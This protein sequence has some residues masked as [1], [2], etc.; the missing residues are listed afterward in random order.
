MKG[1]RSNQLVVLDINK[2][3]MAT[4]E[5]GCVTCAS[6]KECNVLNPGKDKRRDLVPNVA[7]SL[8]FAAL[9]RGAL[10]GNKLEE[11]LE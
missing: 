5:V 1:R 6:R 8:P 2:E 9:K 7:I 4:E 11:F 10:S 3:R